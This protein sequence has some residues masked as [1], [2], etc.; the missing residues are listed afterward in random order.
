MIPGNNGLRPSSKGG[1][2]RRTTGRSFDFG[3]RPRRGRADRAYASFRPGFIPPGRTIGETIRVRRD[4]SLIGTSD[5][6]EAPVRPSET[7]RVR[8]GPCP[9]NRARCPNF[10]GGRAAPRPIKETTASRR[11]RQVGCEPGRG[12]RAGWQR[13]RERPR[14]GKYGDRQLVDLLDRRLAGECDRQ[15]PLREEMADEATVCRVAAGLCGGAGEMSL[16]SR[17]DRMGRTGEIVQTRAAQR[18]RRVA[19]DQRGKQELSNEP[20]H[21][22]PDLGAFHAVDQDTRSA[23]TKRRAPSQAYGQGRD[24]RANHQRR[25]KIHESV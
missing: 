16:R 22:N 5:R 25:P 10:T 15:L 17:A 4:R 20:R 12:A 19:R 7:H 13:V 11:S 1:K 21:G 18:H 2:P 3:D 9:S 14:E 8:R 6:P 23:P 24:D